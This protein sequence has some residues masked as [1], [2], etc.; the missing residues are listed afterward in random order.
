MGLYYLIPKKPILPY[1]NVS[2]VNILQFIPGFKNGRIIQGR[3]KKL[4]NK[5]EEITSNENTLPGRSNIYLK[6]FIDDNLN[7]T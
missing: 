3:K 7:I 2:P 6:Y 1:R 4:Q 5:N